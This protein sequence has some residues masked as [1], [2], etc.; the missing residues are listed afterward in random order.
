[1]DERR[2]LNK[3][4]LEKIDALSDIVHDIKCRQMVV[5]QYMEVQFGGMDLVGT[6][7]EGN[8]TRSLR[9]INEKIKIQNGRIAKA[10]E[11]LSV[12]DNYKW[13]LIGIAIGSGT[14]GS[15]VL[16]LLKF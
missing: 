13:Q 16:R 11:K 9:E 14:V 3:A 4:I 6:P 15:L 5:K 12:L 7:M 1:M 10:E 2:E 8:V